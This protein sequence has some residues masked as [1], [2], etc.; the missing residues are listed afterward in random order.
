MSNLDERGV[1]RSPRHVSSDLLS[2][3][4]WVEN[5]VDDILEMIESYRRAQYKIPI[6]WLEELVEHSRAIDNADEI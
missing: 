4:Q 3:S 2:R 6:E 5:R 1:Y